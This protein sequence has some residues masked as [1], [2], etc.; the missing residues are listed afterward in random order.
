MSRRSLR[1]TDQVLFLDL[2]A[3]YTVFEI[4]LSR[5]LRIHFFVCMLYFNS[6]KV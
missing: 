4:S 2:G 5:M 3:S 1:G 6:F